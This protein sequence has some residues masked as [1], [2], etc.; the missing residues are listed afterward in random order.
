MAHTHVSLGQCQAVFHAAGTGGQMIIEHNQTSKGAPDPNS[1]TAAI[2]GAGPGSP[3]DGAHFCQDDWHVLLQG[4]IEGGDASFTQQ[5]AQNII[6]GL[7]MVLTLDGSPLHT[8]QTATMPFLN[9]A[10]H[11]LTVQN[12]WWF[13]VGEFFP[14][15]S[16]S[17]GQHQLDVSLSDP[18]GLIYQQSTTFFIDAAGTGGC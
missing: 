10:G 14:P 15:N 13:Q 11:G 18:T 12:A 4:D 1:L 7:K 8:T 2:R 5:D 9:P 16:L 3:W 17:V 6:N